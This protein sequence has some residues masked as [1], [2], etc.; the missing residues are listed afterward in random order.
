MSHKK[1]SRD[2]LTRSVEKQEAKAEPPWFQLGKEY[3]VFAADNVLFGPD[4][5]LVRQIVPAGNN[6]ICVLAHD[7][8]Q[9]LKTTDTEVS[10]VISDIKPGSVQHATVCGPDNDM[11]VTALGPTVVVY[12]NGRI[13]F[14]T[15]LPGN[16]CAVVGSPFDIFVVYA[17]G[18]D[19]C[20]VQMVTVVGPIKPKYD[21]VR[22]PCRC[23]L[24][25]FELMEQIFVV[26]DM[27]KRYELQLE[28]MQLEC[29]AMIPHSVS[30]LTLRNDE[31][32]TIGFV[33]THVDR[34]ITCRLFEKILSEW[35][36]IE[37]DEVKALHLSPRTPWLLVV[38]GSTHSL[39]VHDIRSGNQIY[40]IRLPNTAYTDFDAG[41]IL[42]AMMRQ[43]VH[44]DPKNALYV[45][46]TA[47]MAFRAPHVE[48][49][50]I[51][52]K[53]WEIIELAFAGMHV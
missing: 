8:I 17:T 25:Y 18:T 31:T 50:S 28:D 14:Q 46:V 51:D 47:L 4:I 33:V 44:T 23:K 10:C 30:A 27:T 48:N 15:S 19:E 11:L 26:E 42:S 40:C 24:A 6:A 43:K 21:P 45:L 1:A 16:I 52:A 37:T 34:R 20:F 32:T 12:N 35:N 41:Q 39:S 53:V 22:I 13:A 49:T 9:F 29:L 5:P 7:N 3:A 2:T 36:F 38:V